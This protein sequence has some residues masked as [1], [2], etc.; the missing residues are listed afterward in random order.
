MHRHNSD[1]QSCSPDYFYIGFIIGLSFLQLKFYFRLNYRCWIS[2]ITGGHSHNSS[3]WRLPDVYLSGLCWLE[4]PGS[5]ALSPL[6]RE[7]QQQAKKKPVQVC[8][9]IDAAG[10]MQK[11]ALR[12]ENFDNK[13]VYFFFN[14]HKNYFW[15]SS[16]KNCVVKFMKLTELSPVDKAQVRRRGFNRFW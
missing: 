8:F 10:V 6:V 1:G 2:T 9:I 11:K 12:V 3:H 4:I 14:R 5:R 15:L 13:K 7:P 16:E